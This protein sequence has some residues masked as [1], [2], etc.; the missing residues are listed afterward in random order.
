MISKI[1]PALADQESLNPDYLKTIEQ[2]D[3]ALRINDYEEA[4]SLYQEALR[5]NPGEAY[6]EKQ[7]KEVK[8]Q[9]SGEQQKRNQQYDSLIA[10]AD[11]FFDKD[12]YQQALATYREAQQVAPE[13]AYPGQRIS[14]INEITR[15]RNQ[16]QEKY[17]RLIASADSAFSNEMLEEARS[18]YQEAVALFADS[19]YPKKQLAA[20]DSRIASQQKRRQQYDS[21]IAEADDFFD[22]KDF[23]RALS[24][25][26]DAKELIPEDGRANQRIATVEDSLTIQEQKELA[27]EKAIGAADSLY[28]KE[29]YQKAITQYQ[30]AQKIFS[31]RNYPADRISKSMDIMANQREEN[32]M[33]SRVIK[34]AD[35]LFNEKKYRNAISSYNEALEIKPEDAYAKNQIAQAKKLLQEREEAFSLA[36]AQG[37]NQFEKENYQQALNHFNKALTFK[38]GNDQATERRN[39]TQKVLEQLRQEMMKQYNAVIA[40]ADKSYENKDL[41]KAIEKYEEAERINPDADYP[42]E[43]ITKIR[44]YLA[45]H[46]LREIVNQTVTVK[47]NTEKKFSF[48]PLTYRD[49]ANNFIVITAKRTDASAK[50]FLNYGAGEQKHGGVVISGIPSGEARQFVFN[51]ANHR[52]WQENENNWIT[53]YVQGGDIAISALDISKGD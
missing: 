7:I 15:K 49:R 36:M 43:M 26:Q 22:N 53:V 13:K 30:E 11:D 4:L 52:R 28:Q 39:E 32:K 31:G 6:P 37:V 50:V 38:P 24:L 29:E 51:L 27:Y 34:N 25:Y 16:Q 8:A 23:N 47:G 42:G 41:S 19:T 5:L 44:E 40:E 10:E 14:A 45:E 48:Q 20:I 33:Y 21:L 3:L 12:N 46:S 2:A 1:D 9:I 35:S 17:H 18:R